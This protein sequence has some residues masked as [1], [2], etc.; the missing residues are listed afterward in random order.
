MSLMDTFHQVDR[1]IEPIKSYLN[2]AAVGVAAGVF[3]DVVPVIAGV[4]SIAWLGT[5]LWDYWFVKRKARN[6]DK[7]N[8][9]LDVKS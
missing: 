7:R 5:Q 6:G 4:F 3:V 8:E 9:H 1:L 2:W